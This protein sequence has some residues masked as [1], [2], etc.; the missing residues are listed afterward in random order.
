MAIGR[1][2]RGS[3]PPGGTSQ[4]VDQMVVSVGP[5]TLTR[6][7]SLGR[8]S[9]DSSSGSAS[10]PTSP[11]IAASVNPASMSTRQPDGVDWMWVIPASWI[12]L[13]CAAPSTRDVPPGDDGPCPRR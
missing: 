5:Y 7:P 11:V 13:I 1:P 12:S 4:V 8:S 9:R 10:P 2:I 6:R 3:P